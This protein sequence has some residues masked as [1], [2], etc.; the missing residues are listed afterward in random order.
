MVNFMTILR[1][2]VSLTLVLILSVGCSTTLV[3]DEIKKAEVVQTH[4]SGGKWI[5]DSSIAVLPIPVVAFFVP[6]A[7]LREHSAEQ[8][9]NRCGV[10]SQLSNRK[11]SVSKAACVPAGLT[12]ILTLGIFQWCPAHATWEADVEVSPRRDQA[13]ADPFSKNLKHGLAGVSKKVKPR[14][15]G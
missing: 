10:A 8:Y 13:L 2:F 6:H 9:L 1:V 12:R 5:D 4:C 14:R 11:V 7:D 15:G 3:N